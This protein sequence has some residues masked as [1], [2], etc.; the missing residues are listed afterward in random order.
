MNERISI[1]ALKE[2]LD[3][4]H[5]IQTD[6]AMALL[7]AVVASWLVYSRSSRM[8]REEEDWDDLIVAF[9]LQRKA[10]SRFD[11]DAVTV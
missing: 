2:Q 9:E 3:A 6:E 7:E 10:F 8:G 4:R 1:D 5:G 11:F